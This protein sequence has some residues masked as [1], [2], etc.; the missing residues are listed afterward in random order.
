[1][2]YE[3]EIYLDLADILYKEKSKYQVFHHIVETKDNKLLLVGG[4]FGGW[5]FM[6]LATLAYLDYLPNPPKD[7]D[8]V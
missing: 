4:I 8:D 5:L 3:L 7:S 2:N 1:M 6:I